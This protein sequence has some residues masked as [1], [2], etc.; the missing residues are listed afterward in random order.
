MRSLPSA[1]RRE[2]PCLGVSRCYGQ[3][4]RGL[5]G[6]GSACLNLWDRCWVLPNEVLANNSIPPLPRTGL[7]AV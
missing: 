1:G 6:P 5:H 3:C 7:E 4:Y 2:S